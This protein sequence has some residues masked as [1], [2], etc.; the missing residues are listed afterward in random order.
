MAGRFTLTVTYS[1]PNPNYI[2]PTSFDSFSG[3]RDRDKR[4]PHQIDP[5]TR[6]V[7]SVE[8]TPEQWEQ[9]KRD[10]LKAWCPQQDG[11]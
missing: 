3:Y 10:T 11:R 9:V 8:L 5:E 2:A 1:E 7:L 4:E 6:T